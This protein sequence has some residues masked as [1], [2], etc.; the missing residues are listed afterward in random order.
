MQTPR[1]RMAGV[2]VKAALRK[3]MK[4]RLRGLVGEE[5]REQ[6]QTLVAKLLQLPAYK[7]ARSVCLYLSLA[8]E[9]DTAA[10]VSLVLQEGKRCFVPRYYSGGR[11]MDMVL[12]RDM[13]DLTSLPL[14]PWGIRQPA[15]GEQR[16]CALTSGGTDLVV[17]PGLAFTLAGA[18]LGR[19]GGYYD[20][21]LHRA[22][23]AASPPLVVALAFREQ[24]VHS[25]PF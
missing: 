2:A 12:V 4:G 6:S 16:E 11:A 17:V 19:G 25:G 5:R 13:E 1:A 3:E 21:W 20:T 9:V 14:T 10:L 8:T 7:E 18:R 15:E 23:A 22:R 24:V